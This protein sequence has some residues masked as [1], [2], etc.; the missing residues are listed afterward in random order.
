MLA[1]TKEFTM[2]YAE[3]LEALCAAK[4]AQTIEKQAVR[5][6]MDYD[7]HGIVLPPAAVR[8]VV[9]SMSGSGISITDVIMNTFKPTP[10]DDSGEFFGPRACGENFRKLLEMHPTYIE[11]GS[12][13]AGGYMVNF[14]SYRKLG[15]KPD[16][17]CSDLLASHEKYHSVPAVGACQHMCQDLAIGL[18][19]GWG[20][21]LRKIEK[22]RVLNP[23]SEDFYAGLRHV[24]L[25]M[26]NWIARHAEAA[27]ALA[28]VRPELRENLFEMSSINERLV[29]EPPQTFREACQ[30]IL[31]YQLA[32]R[33]YNGSGSLGKLDVL[34]QPFYEA[35]AYVGRLTD[36][37]ATFHL[38]C[39]LLRDTGYIQLGGP[40]STG[41]DVTGKVSYLVLDA[42]HRLRIPANIGVSVGKDVDVKLLKRGV[43][44]LLKDRGGMPKFLGV[45]NTISGFAACGFP[46]ED[47]RDRAYAGCHWSAIPGREYGSMDVIKVSLPRILDI[48][49][50]EMLADADVKPNVE[51]LWTRF[52]KHQQAALETVAMGIDYQFEHMHEVFPEIVLDL[53][54]H[55][56]IEKGL[57]ASHGGVEYYTF[58]VDA[59]GLATVADSFA[60]LQEKIDM[61]HCLSWPEL[62]AH[63]DG[64]W[65][66]PAG[67]IA[68]LTMKYS[69]R[70]GNGESTGDEWAVRI[71]QSF[72]SA[73]V[74]NRT[75]RGLKMIPGIFSWALNIQ[76]GKKLGATPNGRHASDPISHGAS[77]DPGFRRDGAATAMAVA[78]AKVQCGYGNTAPLQ[79]DLDPS[80]PDTPESVDKV[81]ALILG[82]F[83][84]GG[85][86]ININI[87]NKQQVVEADRNPKLFPD[88][89]VRV[90]GFSV[91][92][93]SLSPEMRKLVV[94]RL[95]CN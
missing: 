5:G 42:A 72:S 24:V 21:L 32:A 26:Q 57:D 2:S 85:T 23:E 41:K 35:D 4:S 10:S 76:L 29:C 33:M 40:D 59:A 80:L 31:W 48:A 38:A 3:R 37:E 83:D 15:W 47:A 39:L 78:V 68:R 70:F 66:G 7:D 34:L 92:F 12:S 49:L 94:D 44:I 45:D 88:L 86:Q 20:G 58:G 56:P 14:M 81:A 46:I 28:E 22:N 93:A 30:W 13:L 11:P 79:I 36:E 16:L 77:P 53:L 55:G 89:I 91:Y 51:E 62:L 8:E 6:S 73:V 54:C 60:A 63:M 25:G 87:L 43:E 82:H 52:T 90:T 19:L 17:D 1:G 69:G 95:I 18:R 71:A 84:L 50:R 61:Q 64:D 67:E 27:R 65:A 75:P 9:H 74:K